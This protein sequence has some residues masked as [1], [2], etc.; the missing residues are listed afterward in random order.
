MIILNFFFSGFQLD[1]PITEIRVKILVPKFSMQMNT[2]TD[3]KVVLLS[4]KPRGSVIVNMGMCAVTRKSYISLIII[5]LCR[6]RKS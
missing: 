3:L 1:R 2:S 4:V 6:D 5:F